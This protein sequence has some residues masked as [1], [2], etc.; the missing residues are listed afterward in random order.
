MNRSGPASASTAIGLVT[1]GSQTSCGPGPSATASAATTA[2]VTETMASQRQRA[3][4][5]DPVG[6][7]SRTKLMQQGTATKPAV[8][9]TTI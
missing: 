8:A 3:D 2:A 7:S 1:D 9:A 4:G 5:S 6:V